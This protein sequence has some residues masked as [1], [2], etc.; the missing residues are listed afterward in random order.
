[1]D[2]VYFSFVGFR[3]YTYLTKRTGKV[4]EIQYVN[5][6]INLILCNTGL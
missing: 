5:H 1:M 4:M 6:C 2:F 3:F